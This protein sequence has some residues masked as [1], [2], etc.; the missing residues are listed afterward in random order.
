MDFT[1]LEKAAI[2]AILAKPL[3]GMDLLRKQFATASVTHRDYTGV[4]F[5]TTISVPASIPA[6][7]PESED[8]H[9]ALFHGAMARPASDPEGWIVFHLWTADGYLAQLEAVTVRDV[10]PDEDDIHDVYP[11]QVRSPEP[12]HP[13]AGPLIPDC[14]RRFALW[15]A[16]T[17]VRTLLRT[18]LAALA[19]AMLAAFIATI[20]IARAT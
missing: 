5:Y 14:D 13:S 8:L 4:G 7:P 19:L 15:Q 17:S 2:E 6:L 18:A 20:L 16:R 9:E 3:D 11:C 10:W 12:T 1:R